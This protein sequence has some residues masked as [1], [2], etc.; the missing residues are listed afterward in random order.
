MKTTFDYFNISQADCTDFTSVEF[1]DYVSE[2]KTMSESVL[3]NQE[4]V[5]RAVPGYYRDRRLVIISELFK[6]GAITS[7]EQLYN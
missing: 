6:R 4:K 2:C 1:N 7:T 3:R 5:H